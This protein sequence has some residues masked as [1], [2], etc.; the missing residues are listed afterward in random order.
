MGCLNSYWKTDNSLFDIQEK[1][2]SF[3]HNFRAR[4]VKA[5]TYIKFA[6]E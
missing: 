2:K 1:F 5:L 3:S 6:F 4:R